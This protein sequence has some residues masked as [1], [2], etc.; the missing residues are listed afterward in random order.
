MVCREN[1]KL[2]KSQ[3][4][5]PGLTGSGDVVGGGGL[6]VGLGEC[7]EMT[8][9]GS[10]WSKEI[11]VEETTRPTKALCWGPQIFGYSWNLISSVNRGGS[12]DYYGG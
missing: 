3:R 11:Q 6:W 10:I 12:R 5:A 2:H 1:T 9:R 4:R 8:Q 7:V